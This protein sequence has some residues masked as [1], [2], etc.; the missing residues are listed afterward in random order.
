MTKGVVSGEVWPPLRRINVEPVTNTSSSS[1]ANNGDGRR[2]ECS[3]WPS[4]PSAAALFF[5][6]RDSYGLQH[7]RPVCSVCSDIRSKSRFCLPHLHSTPPL[8][9]S[10]R[11]I[12]IPFGV[13]RLEW[14]G[15][16][17]LKKISKIS[18]FVLTQQTNVT[19]G[20]TYRHTHIHLMTAYAA[21]MHSI[22]LQKRWQAVALNG[23]DRTDNIDC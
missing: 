4:T 7:C 22:A 17:M 5:T 23:I 19:D 15:Y 10:R 11:N 3:A 9:G 16:P 20:Q 14:L 1:C 12:A 2:R 8:G 13:E 18:L 21:L 6:L